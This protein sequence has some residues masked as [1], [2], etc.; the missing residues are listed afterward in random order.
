MVRSSAGADWGT[1]LGRF[2][3]DKPGI[4][5]AVLTRSRCDGQTPYEW[6]TEGIADGQPV[7]DLACGNAPIRRLVGDRWLGIDASITE[8]NAA[9]PDATGRVVQGDAVALPFHSCASGTVLCSMALMLIDLIGEALTEIQRVLRP[10]G[11]LCLLLP[12]R[13][14]LTLRDRARY[15]ALFAALGT[16]TMFPPSPLLQEPGAALEAAGYTIVTNETRR[17]AYPIGSRADANLLVDSLYLPGVTARRHQ[18]ATRVAT[19]WAPGDLGMPVRKIVAT[20]PDDR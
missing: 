20:V 9:G 17:F 19:A 13:G 2:H 4:T 8:L 15:G 3:R 18:A 14:P 1:Y 7:L 5:D 11:A 16:V 10:G 12:A 6:L